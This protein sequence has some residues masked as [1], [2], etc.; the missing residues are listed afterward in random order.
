MKKVMEMEVKNEKTTKKGDRVE[1]KPEML[2]RSKFR[3]GVVVEITT[4]NLM[5]VKRDGYRGHE[6]TWWWIGDWKKRKFL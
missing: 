4:T 6:P 1:L 2:P 5:R 3:T